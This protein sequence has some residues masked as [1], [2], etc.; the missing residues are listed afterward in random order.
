MVN[1]DTPLSA[2]QVFIK[3]IYFLQRPLYEGISDRLGEGT[4]K[5]F[6]YSS[7][8]AE[9]YSCSN[10]KEVASWFCARK[11]VFS[12]ALAHVPLFPVRSSQTQFH[13]IMMM[14]LQ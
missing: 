12:K 2:F 3:Y 9:R 14:K 5:S 11:K 6:D 13:K 4:W 10:F 7:I 8:L 1:D